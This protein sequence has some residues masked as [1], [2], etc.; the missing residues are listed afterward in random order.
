[1]SGQARSLRGAADDVV[2]A[3]FGYGRMELVDPYLD[4]TQSQMEST[5]MFVYS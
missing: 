3:E 2:L 4:T 5:S 1:M